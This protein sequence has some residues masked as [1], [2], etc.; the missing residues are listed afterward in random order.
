MK[1]EERL[2]P[3]MERAIEILYAKGQIAVGYEQQ[4]RLHPDTIATLEKRGLVQRLGKRLLYWTLTP[5][6][7]AAHRRMQ[8][9]AAL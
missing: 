9:E 4:D 1:S 5:E 2:S 7:I 6:G 3:G 8:E